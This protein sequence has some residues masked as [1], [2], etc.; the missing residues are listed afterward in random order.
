MKLAVKSVLHEERTSFQ[1]ILVFESET[2]GRVMVLDGV[3]QLT[4]RDEHAYQEMLTHVAICSHG[5][6]ESVCIIGGGDG[7]IV[8]EV[9]KHRTVTRVVLCEI[10]SRVI[11]ISREYFP[12]LSCALG[13]SRVEIISADGAKYLSDNANVGAFD[14]VIT[15]SSDPVGPAETL[16]ST[17]YHRIVHASL[18][19][20]GVAAAQGECMWLHLDLIVDYMA[21]SREVFSAVEYSSVSIKSPRI[22]F[23]DGSLRYYS[24]EIH[25]ASFTLPLFV[26]RAIDI[27]GS[28]DVQPS[29]GPNNK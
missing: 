28:I 27:N 5:N 19:A 6:A 14:V 1:D 12:Q 23:H 29:E 20:G 13:D 16:F 3:I 15:D 4:T 26:Q 24:P 22:M 9:L 18:K 8:R 2:Y 21:R 10:D 25:R 7:G 11:D 17:E